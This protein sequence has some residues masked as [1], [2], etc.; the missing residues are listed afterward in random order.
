MFDF[1]ELDEKQDFYSKEKEEIF[2][3]VEIKTPILIDNEKSVHYFLKCRHTKLILAKSNREPKGV[4]E[5]H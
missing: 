5:E 3:K 2:G 1:S 4:K